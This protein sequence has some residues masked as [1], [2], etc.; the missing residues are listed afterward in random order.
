MTVAGAAK[1]QLGSYEQATSWYRRA[2]D[3]NRN[4]PHA[5]FELGALAHLGRLGE[6]HSAVET[7]LA[8]NPAFTVS[9]ARAAWTAMSDNP[10]YLTTL[11][12]ILDG[13]RM[14]GVPES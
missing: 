14:A 10:T 8:L 5:H 7:G 12:P 6:A 9:R 4:I 3:A 2:I 13:L 11:E 1:L